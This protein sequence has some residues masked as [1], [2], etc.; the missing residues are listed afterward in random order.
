MMAFS[1]VSIMSLLSTSEKKSVNK[2]I[3]SVILKTYSCNKM[4]WKYF[5][6]GGA[7]L[8]KNTSLMPTGV[9]LCSVVP[10]HS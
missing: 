4:D 2:M 1:L 3:E 5:K 9:I 10:F 6:Q 8:C 7:F